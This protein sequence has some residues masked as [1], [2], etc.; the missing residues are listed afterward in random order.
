MYRKTVSILVVFAFMTGI[1]GCASISQEPEGVEPGA[2]EDALIEPPDAETE[3]AVPGEAADAL[4]WSPV[5]KTE[6]AVLGGVIGALGGGLIG[7]YSYEKKKSKEDTAG[8]YNY[9]PWQG[10]MA[11]IESAS[12][13]P[14]NVRPGQKVELKM[15][16]ALLGA[17]GG[18][19][20]D[21]SETREIKYQGKTFSKPKMFVSREDGT[22]SS[23]IPITVPSTAKKG[24][25]TVIMTVKAQKASDSRQASFNVQ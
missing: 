16:Y 4:T 18:E 15:T 20:L 25:Y 14:Q 21:V 3:V 23:T 10:V 11:K 5:A 7:K 9:K 17:P 2:L 13:A 1:F 24:R 12:A 8:K 22:Y 19:F 6:K